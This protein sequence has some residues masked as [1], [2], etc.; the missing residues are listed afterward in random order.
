MIDRVCCLPPY[1]PPSSYRSISGHLLGQ[2]KGVKQG[3][4]SPDTHL[5][6]LQVSLYYRTESVLCAIF[7]QA[8]SDR[9]Y[10]QGWQRSRAICE[11]VR[12]VYN[13]YRGTHHELAI[14]SWWVMPE[15]SSR[16]Y[17]PWAGLSPHHTLSSV[18]VIGVLL[19]CCYLGPKAEIT[20][21]PLLAD[22]WDPVPPW[23]RPEKS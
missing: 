19:T 20:G 16:P 12:S 5:L 14:G 10:T 8:I 9:S 3:S 1:D 13:E 23:G 21:R 22:S 2:S 18:Q 17:C 4:L 11:P 7:D 6:P 15:A